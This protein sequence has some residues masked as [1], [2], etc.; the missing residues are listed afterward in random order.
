MRV[1]IGC[2]FSI[3][4]RSRAK[5]AIDGAFVTSLAITAENVSFSSV[6]V[7]DSQ[8]TFS[9]SLPSPSETASIQR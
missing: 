8:L 3:F 1:S 6:M 7:M 4:K 5:A 2:S 9:A